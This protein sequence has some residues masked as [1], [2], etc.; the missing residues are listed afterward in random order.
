MERGRERRF[1]SARA[2]RREDETQKA[3]RRWPNTT[4]S[5]NAAMSLP[6]RSILLAVVFATSSS[7]YNSPFHH[8]AAAA[9]VEPRASHAIATM[10]RGV[11]PP[12]KN[13]DD[14][15]DQAFHG[16]EASLNGASLK[17]TKT[18]PLKAFGLGAAFVWAL[19]GTIL[20]P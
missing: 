2:R 13:D 18:K 20:L 19:V 17:L 11:S 8:S 4:P 14:G 5:N 6:L 15:F 9:T 3:R 12:A 10:A 16:A 1:H 7:A